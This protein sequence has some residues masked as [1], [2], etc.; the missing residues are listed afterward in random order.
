MV[1]ASTL[2]RHENVEEPWQREANG[3]EDHYEVHHGKCDNVKRA[4]VDGRKGGV[5]EREDDR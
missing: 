1:L 5:G 4:V 2:H 3:N